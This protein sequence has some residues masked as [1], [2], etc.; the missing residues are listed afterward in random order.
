MIYFP[1]AFENANSVF[2]RLHARSDLESLGNTGYGKRMK[3]IIG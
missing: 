2:A 1:S 3:S